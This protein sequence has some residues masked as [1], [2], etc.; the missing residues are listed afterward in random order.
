MTIFTKSIE[1]FSDGSSSFVT[2]SRK[3]KKIITV[4][5]KDLRFFQKI[6]KNKKGIKKNVNFRKKLFK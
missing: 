1:I 5:D 6:R 4:N 2:G 3:F